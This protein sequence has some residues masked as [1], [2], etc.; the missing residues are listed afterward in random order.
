MI[1]TFYRVNSQKAIEDTPY[2]I[3]SIILYYIILTVLNENSIFLEKYL[4]AEINV[5]ISVKFLNLKDGKN[6]RQKNNLKDTPTT[7]N[8]GVYIGLAYKSTSRC[9]T[10]NSGLDQ[11]LQNRLTQ[12]IQ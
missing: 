6:I 9:L 12:N 4:K 2:Y 11:H 3:K 8:C 10:Q 1:S 5:F 7:V